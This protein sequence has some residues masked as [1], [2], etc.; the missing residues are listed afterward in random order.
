M[1]KHVLVYELGVRY[2]DLLTLDPTLPLPFPAAILI[3]NRALII[4][5]ETVRMIICANQCYVLSVPD[6]SGA[7]GGVVGSTGCTL[8]WERRRLGQV[9]GEVCD[10]C[11]VGVSRA[12]THCPQRRAPALPSAAGRQP[13]QAQPADLRQPVHQEDVRD[14]EATRG[15]AQQHEPAAHGPVSIE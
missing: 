8:A 14:A 1:D 10:A 15:G 4:N 5:L 13:V 11:S 7:G 12:A 3:R 6:V 9:E 2:R